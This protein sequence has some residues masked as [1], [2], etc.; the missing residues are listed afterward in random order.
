MRMVLV[1][2][3]SRLAT[4]SRQINLAVARDG[5]DRCI[6]EPGVDREPAESPVNL[7]PQ[8]ALTDRAGVARVWP[9]VPMSETTWALQ[10]AKSQLGRV[11]RA[12]Q[13]RPQVITRR[14]VPT[15][16]VLSVEAFERLE[17]REGVPTPS[18]A[19]HILAMPQ[20]GVVDLERRDLQP[21]D[22]DR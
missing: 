3:Y 11:V 19:A 2:M 9:G 8:P 15:A 10:D 13:D 16:V 12:A 20:G 21:R 17:R 5:F 22:F 6:R 18:L 7:A 14:G 1:S 4:S